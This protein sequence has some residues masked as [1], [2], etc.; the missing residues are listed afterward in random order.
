MTEIR[1][2]FG[3][4]IKS[5]KIINIYIKVND[6]KLW[7]FQRIITL[8]FDISMIILNAEF[9]F[10]TEINLDAIIIVYVYS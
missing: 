6:W 10:K 9:I 8:N 2:L 3:L 5:N 4:L 1:M 7:H